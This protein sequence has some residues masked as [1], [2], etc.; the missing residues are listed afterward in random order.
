MVLLNRIKSLVFERKEFALKS[1]WETNCAESYSLT[2]ECVFWN[3]TDLGQN[4]K[5]VYSFLLQNMDSPPICVRGNFIPSCHRRQYL[6]KIHKGSS[7][8]IIDDQTKVS[9]QQTLFTTVKLYQQN[10]FKASGHWPETKKKSI[11]SNNLE[12][13]LLYNRVNFE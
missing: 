4:S 8:Q 5:L 2:L 11:V 13:S 7:I 9:V 1:F 10:G 12:A 3:F 6:F